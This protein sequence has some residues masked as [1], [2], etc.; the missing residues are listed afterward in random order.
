MSANVEGCL[1]Y[2]LSSIQGLIFHFYRFMNW[3]ILLLCLE[4]AMA[5]VLASHG[6]GGQHRAHR[7]KNKQNRGG[8]YKLRE[9][10][11]WFHPRTF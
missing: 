8:K 3:L 7:R 10:W 2:V 1:G 4:L 6:G 11:E 9:M 5:P